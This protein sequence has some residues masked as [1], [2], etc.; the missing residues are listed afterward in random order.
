MSSNNVETEEPNTEPPKMENSGGYSLKI[1]KRLPKKSKI[2][3]HCEKQS[4]EINC[5]LMR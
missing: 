5:K 4:F 2:Q 1:K 3:R